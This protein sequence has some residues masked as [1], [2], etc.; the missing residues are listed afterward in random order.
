MEACSQA[1]R[2]SLKEE[3]RVNALRRSENSL[4]FAKWDAGKQLESS[5]LIYRLKE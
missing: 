1:V 3:L 4:K 2:V 5:N